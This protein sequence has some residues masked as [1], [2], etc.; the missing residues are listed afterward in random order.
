M[1]AGGGATLGLKLNLA[2]GRERTVLEKIEGH[3]FPPPLIA[4]LADVMD[5]ERAL[6][7]DPKPHI[8][9]GRP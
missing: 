5:L 8:P 9:G 7:C 6:V 3:F 1:A 2:H 4:D